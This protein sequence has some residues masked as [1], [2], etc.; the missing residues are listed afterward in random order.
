MKICAIAVSRQRLN[1][2]HLS[3]SRVGELPHFTAAA[4]AGNWG[5]ATTL[6]VTQH[7]MYDSVPP[8]LPILQNLLLPPHINK[9]TISVR[10]VSLNGVKTGT[11]SAQKPVGSCHIVFCGFF[12]P[13]GDFLVYYGLFFPPGALSP[14]NQK[15]GEVGNSQIHYHPYNLFFQW[16]WGEKQ[17]FH[18]EHPT[19]NQRYI[20]KLLNGQISLQPSWIHRCTAKMKL[21]TPKL[22]HNI[23]MLTQL[24]SHNADSLLT[25]THVTFCHSTW[26]KKCIFTLLLKFTTMHPLSKK[27]LCTLYFWSEYPFFK[28]AS[29]TLRSRLLLPVTHDPQSFSLSPKFQTGQRNSPEGSTNYRHTTM[30]KLSA[31]KL[32]FLSIQKNSPQMPFSRRNQWQINPPLEQQ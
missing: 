21:W 16:F 27:L 13:S 6:K 4:A 30:Q 7:P 18:W 25:H 10:Q 23:D 17:L 15:L 11:G 20:K 26:E 12:S 19:H 2:R 9:V 14:C 32:T 1:V 5:S 8:W 3:L 31:A 24:S 29:S 28:N 22:D